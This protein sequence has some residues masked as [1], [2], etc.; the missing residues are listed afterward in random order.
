MNGMWGYKVS[1]INYK[2]AE[3]LIQLII[4]A[5]GKGS[6]LLLNIG[7]QPNGQLPHQSL[8]RLK[9]IGEWM[10]KNG[11]TIY[12]TRRT[13]IGDQPWGT[14]TA[15]ER[16]LY[17]HVLTSDVREIEIPL[18]SKPKQ[19]SAP[20]TYDKKQHTL[21]ITLPERITPIDHIVEILL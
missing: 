14:T 7:P 11:H 15:D 16:H 8:A 12:N 3:E 10:K 17:L 2:S 20:S 1:D 4:R 9:Q 21:R 13:A 19:A 6:N 5:A 18:A